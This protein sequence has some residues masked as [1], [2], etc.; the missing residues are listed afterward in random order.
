M[1][2]LLVIAN[3]CRQ[4]S[5]LLSL[6]VNILH[7]QKIMSDNTLEALISTLRISEGGAQPTSPQYWY[8]TGEVEIEF[9]CNQLQDTMCPLPGVVVMPWHS[10]QLH[11][12]IASIEKTS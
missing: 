4:F 11:R 1:T 3:W 5:Q 2:S 8:C 10:R 9:F 6:F 12:T 7:M